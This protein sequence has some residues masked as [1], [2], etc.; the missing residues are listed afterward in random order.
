[1]ERKRQY[2]FICLAP[3]RISYDLN[4]HVQL[5]SKTSD[6]IRSMKK[7]KQLTTS[8]QE[9]IAQVSRTTNEHT[10]T[11]HNTMLVFS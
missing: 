4:Y 3:I 11:L 6:Q 1:M 7:K 10:H 8:Q 5:V 9:K 2:V